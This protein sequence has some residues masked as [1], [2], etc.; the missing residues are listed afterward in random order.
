MWGSKPYEYPGKEYS[1]KKEWQTQRPRGKKVLSI[2]DIGGLE[3]SEL[4]GRVMGDEV[5]E[6]TKGQIIYGLVDHGND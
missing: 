2:I 6:V 3:Y 1:R 4:R 5:R